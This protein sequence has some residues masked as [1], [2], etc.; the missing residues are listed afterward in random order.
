MSTGNRIWKQQLVNIG[1]LQNAIGCNNTLKK[2]NRV[3]FP[4]SEV[5]SL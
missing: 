1:T 3:V 2:E 4:G 5:Y